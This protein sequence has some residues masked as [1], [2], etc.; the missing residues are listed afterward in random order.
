MPAMLLHMHRGHG[1]LL[2]R[3]GAVAGRASRAGRARARRGGGAWGHPTMASSMVRVLLRC[4]FFD[5]TPV[6]AKD[7][8][9][10][11]IEGPRMLPSM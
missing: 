5:G 9:Q 7:F 8:W 3:P 6:R 10:S 4:R 2:H 11:W 1:P